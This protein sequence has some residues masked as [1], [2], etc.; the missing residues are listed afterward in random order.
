MAVN[1]IIEL[2]VFITFGQ[3]TSIN[4]RHLRVHQLIAAPEPPYAD[5]AGHYSNLLGPLYRPL[6]AT[7]ASYRGTGA[8]RIFPKPPAV[9]QFSVLQQGAGSVTGDV[10][11]P[12]T[13]SLI[14]LR[15]ADAGRRFR[16]RIYVPF[17]GE[18]DNSFNGTPSAAYISLLGNLASFFTQDQTITV[19]GGSA[20]YR[21]VIYH[22]VGLTP[23]DTAITSTVARTVWATQRRR[24]GFGRPNA[25]PI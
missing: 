15:T 22:R 19:G 3:Q 5:V 18:A 11:P 1:D 10:L 17:P 6:L 16:G 24:G 21:H 20:L 8:R 23:P 7:G 12:Q 9:E 14:T 25:S 13:T 4:V 2:R